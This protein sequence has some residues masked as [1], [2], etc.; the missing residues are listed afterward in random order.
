MS[1]IQSSKVISCAAF[2]LFFGA[3][4][5]L[6][7]APHAAQLQAL[8]NDAVTPVMQQQNIPGLSVA[9]TINGQPHYFNYGVANKDTGQTVSKNTLFEIG[10]VSKTF[11]ATLAGYAQACLLYT[12]DAADE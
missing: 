6:A 5:C 11:T 7:A 3:T 2:G 10:S 1:S 8:V 9:L 12:S 4:S